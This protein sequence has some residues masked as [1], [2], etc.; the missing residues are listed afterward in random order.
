MIVQNF[1]VT[2]VGNFEPDQIASI[3]LSFSDLG[4][5]FEDFIP[6]FQSK[7]TNKVSLR[8]KHMTKNDVAKTCFA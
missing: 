3:V 5:K 2:H 4:A 7:L 6:K 8:V 1:L